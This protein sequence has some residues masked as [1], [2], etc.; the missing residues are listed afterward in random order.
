MAI[1]TS[2]G[3][4]EAGAWFTKTHWSVVLAA[5]RH[6]TVAREAFGR[7][8]QTYYR[9][10]YFYVRGHGH[11]PAD[12]EDL[13][14]EFFTRLLA[15]NNLGGADPAKGRFRAYLVTALRHFLANEWERANA[16]KRAPSRPILSLDTDSAETVFRV[17]AATGASPEKLYDKR[18]ALTVLE[19]ALTRLRE[20]QTAD[21]KG[22]QYER[23]QQFLSTE[24]KGA[25]YVTLAAELGATREAVAMA[26][27]RLR[28]RFRELVRNEIAQ[29]VASE[30]DVEDELRWLFTVLSGQG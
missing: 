30:K 19:R 16:Q 18:W 10:I 5:G 6:D 8:Y 20:E 25:D 17:E 24:S 2:T 15:K 11:S 29:T 23:L 27:S 3:S 22:A 28:G 21:G 7:L 14:Q 9:P 13:T 26:V 4:S 12:A 1:E